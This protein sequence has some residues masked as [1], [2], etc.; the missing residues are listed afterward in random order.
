MTRVFCSWKEK[1]SRVVREEEEGKLRDEEIKKVSAKTATG[2]V[3]VCMWSRPSRPN[4]KV[5]TYLQH[6]FLH[7]SYPTNTV[8]ASY[9]FFLIILYYL[10]YSISRP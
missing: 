8:A 7:V 5:P 2:G 3:L 9:V 1:E 10:L 6:D 4:Y